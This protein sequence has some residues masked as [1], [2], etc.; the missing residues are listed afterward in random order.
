MG[1]GARDALRQVPAMK[2]NFRAIWRNNLGSNFELKQSAVTEMV[3][4]NGAFRIGAM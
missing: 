2:F 4:R 1:N 3:E